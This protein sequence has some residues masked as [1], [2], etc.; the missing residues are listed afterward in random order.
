MKKTLVL[1]AS[2]MLGSM[3][4]D[5]LSRAASL[6]ITA[7]V[8]E[9]NL[10]R[11]F[12]TLYPNIRWE[13]FRFD[14]ENTSFDLLDGQDWVLNA[15]GITKPLVRDDD[16]GQ[17]ET[18][19]RVNSL[20]PHCLGRAAKVRGARVLQIATDCVYSGAKGGYRE[21]DI[22]DAL[23]VY[24]K[25]KSL[26]ES[27]QENVQHLRCSIIGPEPKDFKFLVEWFRCQ[28][29]GAQVNG[30]TNHYWN[31]LTTLQFARICMGVVENDL[32]L[33]HLQ[34]VVPAD[35]MAK[36]DMLREFAIAYNRQ[37]MCIN[38]VEAHYSIDR[39][40]ATN[41]AELNET[42]WRAAGYQRPPSVAEMIHEM[43]HYQYAAAATAVKEE[44]S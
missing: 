43:A 19:I 10:L 18:A 5:F 34:H 9:P 41:N 22:H 13:Q 17:I 7:S 30:F 44:L 25:T 12:Q 4:V 14:G 29:E 35:S 26:G 38:D 3:M 37:D 21:T 20:L 28:P 40:L 2:G 32:A 6:T 36:A 39:T 27:Y 33:P 31:G 16:A 23:D 11:R 24:G 15:I 42:L 1:G 8:R